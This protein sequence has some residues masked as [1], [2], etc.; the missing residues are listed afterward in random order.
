M[1]NTWVLTAAVACRT[2]RIEIG[3]VGTN[4]FTT[5]PS[6]IASWLATLD[7][8][9]AGRALLGLGLHT[10][11][12]VEW[13]GVGASDYLIRT[14]EATE[15]IRRLLR[16]EV[17]EFTGKAFNWS[18][19]CYLRFEPRR[20]DVPIYIC[21][22]GPGYLELSGRIGD[23]SLPMITPPESAA[24][25]V[26]PIRGGMQRNPRRDRFVIS[27]CAWLSLS[28]TR[29]AAAAN[30]RKMVAYFGPYFEDESLAHIGLSRTDFEPIRTLVRKR[31]YEA[32][33][34]AVTD[35][36]LRLGICGTPQD[37]IRQLEVL[38]DL[39]I[40]EI[41]LGGPLGPDPMEAIRLMGERIIP[42]FRR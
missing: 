29:K 35:D 6:E 40:D 4:P 18:D 28:G 1:R 13:S 37:V 17:A 12:M 42:H 7:E 39:G 38:A 20:Q 2:S 21:A 10:T 25:M 32:A 26:P 8:L 16:G 3:S 5:D 22:F 34:A 14:E 36:M 24:T 31:D 30:M 27:G 11:G 9:S 19:Q 15:L 41:N 33:Y 23:G